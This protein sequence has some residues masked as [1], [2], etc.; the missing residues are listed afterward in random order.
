MKSKAYLL[1]I[2]FIYIYIRDKEV[3]DVYGKVDLPTN[4]SINPTDYGNY[5][6]SKNVPAREYYQNTQQVKLNIC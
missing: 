5:F 1:I 2:N 6:F 3:D 4:L